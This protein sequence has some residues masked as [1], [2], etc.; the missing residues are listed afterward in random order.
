MIAEPH[1]V[2]HEVVVACDKHHWKSQHVE[3]NGYKRLQE[4]L[5]AVG[6]M[7]EKIASA[8]QRFLKMV[9]ARASFRG[10]NLI[11]GR[12]IAPDEHVPFFHHPSKEINVFAACSEFRSEG[13]RDS[14]DDTSRK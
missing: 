10:N 13:F 4:V 12:F 14:L 9:S 2:I 1:Q 6:G 8:P 3:R 5:C 11:N 7:L